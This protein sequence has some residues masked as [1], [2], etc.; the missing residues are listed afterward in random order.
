M[1]IR[2]LTPTTARRLAIARQHLDGQ[3]RPADNMLDVI[4]D[5]GCLQLDPTSAV[6]RSHLLVLWSRL[7]NY[8]RAQLDRL[9]WHDRQ[10]FEYWAH[11]AS[12]VLTEDY[13][14]HAEM[15]SRY[16]NGEPAYWQKWIQQNAAFRDHILNELEK[17]GPL[18]SKD[19]EDKTASGWASTGWTSGRNVSRML[20]FLWLQGKIL[21]KER[22]GQTRYWDLAERCLPDWTPRHALS[23]REV[24]RRSAQRALRALGV[25]RANQIKQHFTRSRYPDL[26]SVLDELEAEGRIQRVKIAGDGVTWPG[27]WYIH[28]DELPLLDRLEAGD[29]QPRTTLLSPFDNLIAD[30]ARTESMFHFEYRIEIYV[31]KDK[32]RYGYFVLPILHGDRLIGRIDPLLDRKQGVLNINAVYAEPGAPQDRDT[33]HTIRAAI[34]NLATFL[35]ATN[36]VYTDRVPEGWKTTLR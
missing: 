26:P 10:L 22:R 6:A 7:G 35:G 25:A 1:T 36:I 20:D 2:T 4:R 31:P 17:R 18:S 14:I 27:V 5:L 15:M 3:P 24:V 34:E 19:F 28:T 8:D 12:I 23:R 9:L 11:A 32:R 16:A 30:R 29:W 13:P 33:A 21:V